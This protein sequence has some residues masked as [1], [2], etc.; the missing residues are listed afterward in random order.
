MRA[1]TISRQRIR[2]TTITKEE[3]M[4]NLPQR[5]NLTRTAC[6]LVGG[7]LLAGLLTACWEVNTY[8][9]VDTCP[10][11]ATRISTDPPDAGA[12]TNGPILTAPANANGAYI[13]NTSPPQQ[14]TDDLHSCNI[15]TRKCA[16]SPGTCQRKPCWTKFTPDSPGAMTGACSCS[17]QWN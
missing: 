6:S 4:R 12:C 1:W 10:P 3:R 8:V 13:A 17:C 11:G 16:L 7:L 14:I 2:S 9:K 15:G 5:F